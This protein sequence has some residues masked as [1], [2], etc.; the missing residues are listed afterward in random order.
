MK[1]TLCLPSIAYA[2]YAAL[3]AFATLAAPAAYGAVLTT[4]P[5]EVSGAN[6]CLEC[7]VVNVSGRDVS[8]AIEAVA[9]DGTT[10]DLGTSVLA[11][12]TATFA[13]AHCDETGDFVCRFDVTGGR[14][15]VRAAACEFA[16]TLGCQSAAAAQ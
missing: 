3:A 14:R 8:V 12:E 13:L 6:R 7:T 5:L 11:P 2:A 9:S 4:Q 10:T 16:L 1:R 15:K